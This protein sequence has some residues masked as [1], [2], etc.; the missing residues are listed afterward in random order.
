[1]A[2]L[3]WKTAERQ[4]ADVVQQAPVE[5]LNFD[6]FDQILKATAGFIQFGGTVDDLPGALL[7]AATDKITVQYFK[8][9][10]R[11]S[12]DAARERV[13]SD[14]WAVVPPSAD[15]E[16]SILTLAV[17]AKE[18][19]DSAVGMG[20]TSVSISPVSPADL[21]RTTDS[22]AS[23]LRMIHHYLT[24]MKAV[25]ALASDAFR[26]VV[27]LVEYYGYSVWYSL[28][29]V[30]P[31]R[32]FDI[33]PGGKITFVQD[34][35]ALLP[36]GR[37]ETL[38]RIV[39][40]VQEQ[41]MTLPAKTEVAPEP[42]VAVPQAASA[43][44]DFQAISWYL[45]SISH[46]LEESLPESAGGLRKRTYDDL[47]ASFLLEFAQF[48]F[49]YFMP[50]LIQLTEFETQAKAIRWTMTDA[51]IEPHGYVKGWRDAAV[52]F[53]EMVKRMSV[54]ERRKDDLW[55]ALWLYTNFVLLNAFASTTKVTAHGRQ[56][57][58]LDFST[59]SHD[60]VE[61]TGKRIQIDESWTS[62]YIKA[63]FKDAVDF[64]TWV[65]QE[66]KRYTAVQ[67]LALIDT[68]LAGDISRQTKKEL[69][70]LVQTPSS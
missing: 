61:L 36:P 25:P 59:L 44:E 67:I 62:N 30:A 4:V 37:F 57:M 50:G 40:H 42:V 69:R 54:P 19:A 5:S 17:P 20:L 63:F 1:L 45:R 11:G 55:S 49:P 52:E 14:I 41:Q 23:I 66:R 58:L 10:H 18:G 9:F 46:V 22:C 65:V 39:H 38:S 34:R 32:P 70:T 7:E 21:S 24:L 3:L 64:K 28:M 27:E 2:K 6:T 43:C 35:M 16:R 47:I 48:T 12:I 56:A 53:G 33:G 31:L 68:G 60:F 13:E 8:L 15:F 51:V 26:G 29:L